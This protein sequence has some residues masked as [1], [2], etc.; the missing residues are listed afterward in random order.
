MRKDLLRGEAAKDLVEKADL[1]GAGAGGCGR[2]AV[3][4]AVAVIE[5]VVELLAIAFDDFAD[6]ASEELLAKLRQIG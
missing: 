5:R 2:A 6:A 4:D 1:D 3:L